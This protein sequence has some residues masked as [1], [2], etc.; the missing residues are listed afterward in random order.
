[1]NY[2][3]AFDQAR[4]AQRFMAEVRLMIG[5]A[6]GNANISESP[7]RLDFQP[8]V[9]GNAHEYFSN[10]KDRTDDNG[11]TLPLQGVGS[12]HLLGDGWN[13]KPN[14]F[15]LLSIVNAD[16]PYA[17]VTFL[18][19]GQTYVM[20]LE[21]KGNFLI[22]MAVGPVATQAPTGDNGMTINTDV[23][24]VHGF[25]DHIFVPPAIELRP[26]VI[27]MIIFRNLIDPF[28]KPI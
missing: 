25:N 18:E 2:K 8:A 17:K 1:M 19:N 12:D 13:S 9:L 24:K 16:T 27:C 15:Y 21:A 22:G 20:N 5:D 26:N 14:P 7:L 3:D 11:K 6:D 23:P 4:Q 28:H 10:G